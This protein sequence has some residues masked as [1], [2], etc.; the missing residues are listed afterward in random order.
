L[1]TQLKR[2]YFYPLLGKKRRKKFLHQALQLNLS[3]FYMGRSNASESQGTAQLMANG[4]VLMK[5]NDLLFS[6][7]DAVWQGSGIGH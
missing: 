4:I 3:I 5:I 2:L 1:T 7:L 6:P